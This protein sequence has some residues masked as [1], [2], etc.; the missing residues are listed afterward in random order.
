VVDQ[1]IHLGG[2]PSIG[3]ITVDEANVRGE[4]GP[5]LPQLVLP[6][7][8]A[9]DP[10]PDGKS[11][12][13]LAL[14]ASLYS[15]QQT[16]ASTVACQPIEIGMTSGFLAWSMTNGKPGSNKI[17]LRFFL[18]PGEIEALERKRHEAS[19]DRLSLYLE[20]KPSVGGLFNFSQ[21]SHSRSETRAGPFDDMGFGVY[22]QVFNFWTATIQTQSFTTPWGTGRHS[23][24]GCVTRGFAK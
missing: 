24:T 20:L 6:I 9:L 21:E 14:R 1:W 19:S 7:T 17:E 3:K 4:G 8:I 16:F 23:E 5:T 2:G 15:S 13:L 10:Q 12:A 18:R 22:A 11:L